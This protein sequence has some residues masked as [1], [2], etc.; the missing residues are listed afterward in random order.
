MRIFNIGD[1]ARVITKYWGDDQFGLTGTVTSIK[2]VTPG[3]EGISGLD[4]K[5]KY[6]KIFRGITYNT[7]HF[8]DL[9][10]LEPIEL[11]YDPLQQGDTD[12][13]I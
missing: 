9:E 13:D 3:H 11:K 12:D 10:P 7:Y 6:D 5:I 4:I 1:H 2:G 8:K